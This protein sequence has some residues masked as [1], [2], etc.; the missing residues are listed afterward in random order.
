MSRH[1]D[2]SRS[3]K[4]LL[5]EWTTSPP[6][7]NYISELEMDLKN[8]FGRIAEEIK[9]NLSVDAELRPHQVEL[10]RKQI[11][12]MAFRLTSEKKN[13]D[14]S[15]TLVFAIAMAM[16]IAQWDRFAREIKERFKRLK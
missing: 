7:Q 12:L 14:S 11:E 4:V 16:Q 6:K 10:L 3:A 15:V 8:L 2:P 13:A 1:S 5:T 9:S